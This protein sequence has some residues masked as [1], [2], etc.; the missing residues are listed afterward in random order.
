MDN[1]D[2]F[3]TGCILCP[4]KCGAN[5]DDGQRG[6]CGE[7]SKVRI[8]R[9][10]LHMWEEPCISGEQGSGTVFFTGCS[11]KCVF[12]QNRAISGGQNGVEVTESELSDV[13]LKLQDMGAKNINLVTPTHF[14]PEI[15]KALE[16]SKSHGL[17]LPIV[18]N[19]SSY[20]T[21]DTLKMLSGL[22]DIYLP[23]FKYKSTELSSKYSGAPDY[24]EVAS[25]AVDEMIRQVGKADGSFPEMKRGVIVRHLLLP[26]FTDDSKEII[27]Y[28]YGKYGNDIFISIM[29]QFTPIPELSK[30]PEINRKVTSDEYD[31][32]IDYALSLG[33]TNAFIQEDG[34][35]E[36]SFIPDF[37]NFSLE[38]FLHG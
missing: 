14:A 26:G 18:Y 4:H 27:S 22:V 25:R 2:S 32:V 31:D 10:S 23:D 11:L 17:S 3:K 12:C 34:T 20:E 15:V 38:K 21:V 36:E 9:A 5:R 7:T 37:Y 1:R 35:A 24:F 13:F 30:Y 6:K 19:T 33:V 29:N 28:L 8:A 16:I